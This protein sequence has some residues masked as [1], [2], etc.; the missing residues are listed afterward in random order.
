MEVELNTDEPQIER[1]CLSCDI[2]AAVEEEEPERLRITGVVHSFG[3]TYSRRLLHP[4]GFI[5]WMKRNPKAQLPMLAAHGYH[6]TDAVYSTIGQW[7]SFSYHKNRG[8]V[9]SG[10]IG[11]GTKL[12]EESRALVKQKL[13]TQLSWGWWPRRQQRVHIGDEDLDPHFKRIMEENEWDDALAFTEFD[14]CE[15][16]LVDIADD[17]G[18]RLAARV[19]VAGVERLDTIE[20]RVAQLG[21]RLDR[22]SAA[23][24]SSDTAALVA[25]LREHS[26]EWFDDFRDAVIELLAS[27]EAIHAAARDLR[28]EANDLAHLWGEGNNDVDD[29]FQNLQDRVAGFGV[30][31]QK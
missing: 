10:W 20:Q 5:N 27:D 31:G 22:L 23:G 25:S 13:L 1:A 11:Q 30:K 17:P 9:W 16:S 24:G 12:Q 8:A 4:Q 2:S 18:A 21:Q 28:E 3:A 19:G 14:L 15:A 7:D 29:C 6:G 26:A